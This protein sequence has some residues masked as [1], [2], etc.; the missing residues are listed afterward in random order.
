MD[1]VVVVVLILGWHL[2][3]L[4]LLRLLLRLGF[5]YVVN[6]IKMLFF[7]FGFRW[8]ILVVIYIYSGFIFGKLRLL[9]FIRLHKYWTF[10]GF[11]CRILMI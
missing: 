7:V 9:S 3:D 4:L 2:I 11:C 1:W 8:Q 6:K 5:L 10:L